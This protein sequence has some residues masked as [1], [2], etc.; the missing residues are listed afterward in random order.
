[1]GWHIPFFRKRN[2][3]IKLYHPVACPEYCEKEKEDI[4]AC[5]ETYSEAC[6][7]SN[8]EIV[9]AGT[10]TNSYESSESSESGCCSGCFGIF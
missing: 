3:N 6:E 4:T 5:E 9:S 10:Q 8:L 7:E 2:E 1:M